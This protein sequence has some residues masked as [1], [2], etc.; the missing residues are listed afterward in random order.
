MNS[1]I[2][3]SIKSLRLFLFALI[4]CTL[5]ACG[6]GNDGAST[7]PSNVNATT[8]DTTTPTD[9][10]LNSPVDEQT[11]TAPIGKMEIGKI[12]CV[13]CSSCHVPETM[14]LSFCPHRTN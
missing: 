11:G 7:G 6:G 10:K 12:Y 1:F 4:L 3:N 13:K 5:A 14:N 2:N 8:P 9:A